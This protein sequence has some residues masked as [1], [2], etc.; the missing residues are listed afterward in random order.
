MINDAREHHKAVAVALA[1]KL[2]EFGGKLRRRLL[3]QA[4]AGD[5]TPSLSAVLL[6]LKKDGPHDFRFGQG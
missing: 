4:D 2:E 5:P 6:R 1:H 3:E